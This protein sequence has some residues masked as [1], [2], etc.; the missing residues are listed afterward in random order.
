MDV[1]PTRST[2]VITALADGQVEEYSTH[3]YH[4]N[5]VGELSMFDVID[6]LKAKV[7]EWTSR[8]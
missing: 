7:K 4:I 6:N 8:L 3:R 5:K 1:S 2:K